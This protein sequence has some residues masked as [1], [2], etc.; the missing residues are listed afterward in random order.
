MLEIVLLCLAAGLAYLV[1]ST[2]HQASALRQFK[3]PWSAQFSRLWIYRATTSGRQHEIFTNVNTE[4]GD[5]ARIGPKIL[6]TTNPELVKLMSAMRSP[7]TRSEFYKG[8]R[9]HPTRDHVLSLQDE[10]AHNA[11]RNR[12]APGELYILCPLIENTNELS[13][14]YSGKE[15][16]RMEDDIDHQLLKFFGLV[17]TS[18]ISTEDYYRPA[19][20]S[21]VVAYLMLDIISTIA[22]GQAFGFMDANK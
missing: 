7:F 16:F 2:W 8:L 13:L 6:L 17:Q 11:M 5:L 4:Y 1:A 21:R 10:A 15:N 20:L 19:D 14:G 18:Y 9:L 12:L 22:F 3:G